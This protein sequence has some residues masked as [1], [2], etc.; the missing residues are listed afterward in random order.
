MSDLA[1]TDD[2]DWRFC[3]AE[4]DKVG[5]LS[6]GVFREIYFRKLRS[7]NGVETLLSPIW[8]EVLTRGDARNRSILGFKVENMMLSWIKEKGLNLEAELGSF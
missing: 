6:T 4:K 3:F 1:I 5:N 8:S 7:V 2:F